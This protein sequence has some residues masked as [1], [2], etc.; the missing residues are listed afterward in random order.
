MPSEEIYACIR[1]ILDAGLQEANDSIGVLTSENR[2]TWA[3]LR[4]QLVACGNEEALSAIDT[5]LF[6]I[7][8][9]ETN[10]NEPDDLAHG[11]LHGNANNR[12]FDKNHTLIVNANGQAGINFEH[13]WG[14]G[15][16]MIRFFNEI[17]DDSAKNAFVTA[18]T[19]PAFERG[20]LKSY[21]KKLGMHTEQQQNN[22]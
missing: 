9:D 21:V 20:D 1:H 12:W 3:A 4:E 22:P 5:A 15:V 8:L 10:S 18:S 11:F 2:D 14:D 17:Y 13:S 19:K 16:A 7:S 6:C